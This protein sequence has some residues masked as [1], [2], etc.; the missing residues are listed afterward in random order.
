[1][2]LTDL[3]TPPRLEGRVALV[4]GGNRGIGRAVVDRLLSERAAV[5]SIQ[6]SPVS[7]TGETPNLL[8]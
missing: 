6:R 7:D 4:T 5:I 3:L 2:S 1:M 8:G